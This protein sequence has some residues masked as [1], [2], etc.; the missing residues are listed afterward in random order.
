MLIYWRALELLPTKPSMA[1]NRCAAF[2]Y[3]TVVFVIGQPILSHP[4]ETCALSRKMP[5]ATKVRNSCCAVQRF[6]NLKTVAEHLCCKRGLGVAVLVLTLGAVQVQAECRVGSNTYKENG[7]TTGDVITLTVIKQWASGDDIT[8]CE[9]STLTDLSNAFYNNT[10]FNQDLSAWDTSAVT[11]MYRMFYGATGVISVNLPKTGAVTNMKDMFAWTVNLTSVNLPKTGAVTDMSHMFYQAKRL[12]TVDLPTTGAVKTMVHMF[13]YATALTAVNL[14]NTGAVTDMNHMFHHAENLTNVSIPNTGA[15]T[16]MR[17]MFNQT[18][19]LTNVTLPTTGAVEDMDHMF[20]GAKKLTTVTIPNTGSVTDF[21]AM[22]NECH[23]LE[24]VNMS[25]FGSATDMRYFLRN[26]RVFVQDISEWSIPQNT[27]TSKMFAGATA[28]QSTYNIDANG[29]LN[30]GG[31]NWLTVAP[32]VTF[33]PT[34]G[35]TAV[36]RDSNIT[37]TF[38][39]TVTLLNGD[40]LT[41]SNVDALITLKEIDANGDDVAFD[42]T[43]SGDVIIVNP[44]NDFSSEQ[45]IYV[46][47]GATAQDSGGNVILPASATFTSVETIAPTI[48]SVSLNGA[49]DEL[50]VTFSED[51]YTGSNGADDLLAADFALTITGGAAVL[52]SPTPSSI[53]KTSQTTWVLGVSTSG[54]ANGSQTISVVPATNTSIYDATGNAAATSQSNNTA[55]LTEK[56]TPTV[57][58]S[59]P[60][61]VVSDDFTVTLTFSEAVTGFTAEDVAVA[62]GTKGAF[63]G[64]GA[65]YTLMVTSTPGTAV[66]VSVPAN[67]A[68]DAAGNGNLAS[69]TFKI[70]TGSPATEFAEKQ[71][72]IKEDIVQAVRQSLQNAVQANVRLVREAKSRF[73]ASREDGKGG[74]VAFVGQNNVPFDIAGNINADAM[75]ISTRGSFFEQRSTDDGQYRRVFFGDYSIN[76]EHGGSVTASLSGKLA[77]EYQL[78]DQTMLGYFIGAEVNQTDIQTEFTGTQSGIGFKTGA[79]FVT[80][81]Y[82]D[83]FLDGFVS[84]GLGQSDLDM[85]DDTLTLDGSYRPRSLAIGAAL[86]GV[87]DRG[88]YEIW[89][90]LAATFAHTTIGDADFTGQAYGVVDNTLS[91]DAGDVT[92]ATMTARPE[93][94]ISLIEEEA[95]ARLEQF[96]FAPRFVCERIV[97]DSVDESCG[98]GVDIGFISRSQ[99]GMSNLTW[100]LSR[101][102]VGNSTRTGFEIKI[103]HSF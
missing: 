101:D 82:K 9:V 10:A 17:A 62:N 20:N 24:T 16:N 72:A 22:F 59:G 8:T 68:T 81:V 90:E 54:I 51:V 63:A 49:N 77:W 48:N 53:A 57:T 58:L 29:Q 12:T 73:I 35:A 7:D 69:D 102:Y 94:R 80:E 70:T 46:A 66:E 31:G 87:F 86:T 26:A 84:A 37:L 38:S 44:D 33:A 13:S 39:E 25:N 65:S 2:F 100:R 76:G 103:Q 50:T 15:V 52:P 85:A 93:V 6:L 4:H 92:I 97:T 89:P 32:T 42:A 91:L 47:I 45:A 55:S 3:F 88:S 34:E 95:T 43:V 61:G 74:L 67:A 40:A 1:F 98:G 96:T 78:S 71:E 64:S 30:N 11:N 18:Y 99:D 79:Y 19:E 28:M 27:D 56:V 36:A 5:S 23:A 21:Y 83:V 14:P 75:R 41:D 60:S